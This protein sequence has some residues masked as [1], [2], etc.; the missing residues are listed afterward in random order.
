[1]PKIFYFAFLLILLDATSLNAFAREYKES[2]IY[3]L[4]GPVME[5]SM[6]T[7]NKVV[8]DMEEITFGTEG[9]SSDAAVT[10]NEEGFPV[11]FDNN[12]T[13]MAVIYDEKH[14][15][16]A[17]N[18]SNP[19]NDSSKS[20]VFEYAESDHPDTEVMM[21]VEICEGN[22]GQSITVYAYTD[23]EFDDY[24]N[25]ISRNVTRA[26]STVEKKNI[27]DIARYSEERTISYY[28]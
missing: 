21:M 2:M 23:Y 11:T 8:F 28:E 20:Y 10:F 13:E 7:E 5:M 17:I 25:W 15:I 4:I 19:Q 6:K 27:E 22:G 12:G 16:F 18:E 26:S 24:G 9:K 14:R 1:M 3:G